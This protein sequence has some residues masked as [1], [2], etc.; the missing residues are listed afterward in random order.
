MHIFSS[1]LFA[2]SA[3]IDCLAVGLSY[4]IKS[5][6]IDRKSNLIIACISCLGTF[7]SMIAGTAISKILSPDIA[8]LAGSIL[9]V[10]IGL[11]MLIHALN[12]KHNDTKEYDKDHSGRIDVKEAILLAFA[13]TINNMGLGIGGSIT[14]LPIFWTC[15]FTFCLSILFIHVAQMIGKKAFSSYIIRY[16]DITSG[17]IILCL[18]LIECIV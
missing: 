2:I 1:V 12:H 9:L 11:Y 15:F 3:N 7:L 8:N 5:V 4:G 14:G 17:L 18:G 16:A 6:I 13:L 10:G